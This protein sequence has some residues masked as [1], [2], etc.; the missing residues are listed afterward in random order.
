MTGALCSH[1]GLPIRHALVLVAIL[2]TA[3][4][5]WAAPLA[6]PSV[7]KLADGSLLDAALGAPDLLAHPHAR[8]DPD[9]TRLHEAIAMPSLVPDLPPEVRALLG[10]E[11]EEPESCEPDGDASETREDATVRPVPSTCRGTVS[12]GSWEDSDVYAVAG[13]ATQGFAAQL[14]IVADGYWAYLCVYS[15]DG[16]LYSHCAYA[17]IRDG[18]ARIEAGDHEGTWHVEVYSWDDGTVYELNLTAAPV[19]GTL[20]DCASGGDAGDSPRGATPI[21]YPVACEAELR[22]TD[23]SDW[24]SVDLPAGEWFEIVVTP[25]A[26]HVLQACVADPDYWLYDC[27]S[28][29]Q[30]G[31]PVTLRVRADVAGAW[32]FGVGTWADADIAHSIVVRPV[33]RTFQD[34]CGSGEDASWRAAQAAPLPP[35]PLACGAAFDDFDRLDWFVLPLAENEYVRLDVIE[36]LGDY[37]VCTFRPSGEVADCGRYGPFGAAVHAG[38]DAGDWLVAVFVYSTPRAGYTLEI[39]SDSTFA[40]QNDCGLLA[41]APDRRQGAAPLAHPADCSGTVHKLDKE[42]HYAVTLAGDADVTMSISADGGSTYLCALR[43]DGAFHRCVQGGETRVHASRYPGTWTFFV[44]LWAHG[45]SSNYTIGL[46]DAP[47]APPQDDCGSGGDASDFAAAPTS[48]IAPIRCEGILEAAYFDSVDHYDFAVPE[49]TTFRIDAE[50][51]AYSVLLDPSGHARPARGYHTASSDGV[52][53]LVL[54]TYGSTERTYSFDV[55]MP[56]ITQSSSGRLIVS[57]DAIH[58]NRAVGPSSAD[59]IDGTWHRLEQVATGIEDIRV[60]VHG[61][62]HTYPEVEYFDEHLQPLAGEPCRTWRNEF[63]QPP[64][65]AQWVHM[66]SDQGYLW[67]WTLHYTYFPEAA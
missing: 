14:D 46:R 34:D 15:H 18:P 64:A 9:A 38:G 5:A 53:S 21:P 37:G 54:Y 52:W 41:D 26:E 51:D 27:A 50:T 8:I 61:G 13:S 55:R 29:A 56:A 28:A 17:S 23:P 25:H 32:I 62:L 10:E 35:L 3:T 48:I 42:D 47:P 57:N 66:T 58:V 12:Y 20:D 49:N 7:P 31:L 39:V 2:I 59:R 43:P 63:C 11:P 30:P 16:D 6:A 60:E 45:P 40:P 67:S 22:A 4:P 19:P 33:A 24:Y 36:T 65:G 1:G 44:L